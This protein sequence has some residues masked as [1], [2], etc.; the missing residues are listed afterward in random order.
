MAVTHSAT[1]AAAA[2]NAVVDLLDVGTGR[3]TGALVYQTSG[4]VEVA[5]CLLSN[6]A[7]G[8]G[9]AAAPSVA[10]AATITADT[11]ATGG[12]IAKAQ[13][14]DRDSAAHILCSVTAT[15]GG[16]DIE[17]TSVVV[18]ALETVDTTSLTYTG[19]A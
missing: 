4:G 13:L 3:A 7:F 5:T 11:S 2:T 17:I 16:G 9:T 18:A 10:T 6:P 19:P 15:G 8:A 14:E 1:A 12:T